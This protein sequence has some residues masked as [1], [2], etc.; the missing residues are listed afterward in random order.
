MATDKKSVHEALK[1]QYLRMSPYWESKKNVTYFTAFLSIFTIAFFGVFAIRPTLITAISLNKE[2]NDFRALN[3]QYDTKISSIV[4]AQS[5]YEKIRDDIS[6]FYETLPGSPQFTTLIMKEENIASSSA[7]QLDSLQMDPLPI[8]RIQNIQNKGNLVTFNFS[9]KLAGNYTDA[10]TYI[11]HLL[12]SQRLVSI[13]DI[14]LSQSTGT[15]SGDINIMLTAQS[16]Y[17][18]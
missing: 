8:S 16:Y 10:Y 18:Q 3:D 9:M 14:T 5:E 17:E 4:K 6:L 11:N 7:M 12:K 2:I 13:S 15:S 1:K